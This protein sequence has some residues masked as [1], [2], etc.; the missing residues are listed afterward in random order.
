MHIELT[1][2]SKR[3]DRISVLN[4]V[5]L[6]IESGRKVALIG[7]NGSGKTTLIRALLGL[8]AADGTIKADNQP[9]G[10][11][12]VNLRHDVAYVPQ[13]APQIN[14]SVAEL[15][16]LISRTRGLDATALH[17]FCQTMNLDLDAIWRKAFRSLSGGMRQKFLIATAFAANAALIV[18]DEPTASLDADARARFFSLYQ[19]MA[20]QTTC[21]LSSHRLEELQALVDHVVALSDGQVVFQGP[22]DELIGAHAISIIDVLTE[23][24]HEDHL[25]TMGFS[26]NPNGWWST[27]VTLEHKMQALRDLHERLGAHI[28]NL[29]VRDLP[30]LEVSSNLKQHPMD[31]RSK[32]N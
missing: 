25:Y 31:K 16:A 4:D 5:N 24:S 29:S 9:I 21:I 27:Q 3:F 10:A 22:V 2:L 6:N 15:C 13:V 14:A 8:V 7:P 20:R 17:T 1:H 18:M 23:S 11:G 12:L 28:R 19:K 30:H 26:P 32:K